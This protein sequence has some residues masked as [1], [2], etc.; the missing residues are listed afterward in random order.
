[1]TDLSYSILED[2]DKISCRICL[3]DDLEHNFISPCNC[4]GTSKYVHKEC[5][6][7]WRYSFEYSPF[8]NNDIRRYNECSVCNSTYSYTQEKKYYS[9]TE[10]FFLGLC[11]TFYIA[12]IMNASYVCF[13][14]VSH[15]IF[16]NIFPTTSSVY[17]DIYINGIFITHIITFLM[18]IVRVSN[19]DF[20]NDYYCN[21][22]YYLVAVLII[23]CLIMTIFFIYYDYISK[24]YYMRK[25]YR[26]DIISTL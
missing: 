24:Q 18:Y 14:L 23:I 2:T 17:L 8:N 6:N 26:V 9:R 1:M 21:E 7:K 20:L 11:D 4:S 16:E 25:Y 15:G 3:E 5:L 13:G 19:T 12:F 22:E 10:L